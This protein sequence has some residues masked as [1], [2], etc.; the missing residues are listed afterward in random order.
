MNPLGRE[1]GASGGGGPKQER[2][3]DCFCCRFF[4]ITYEQQFPYGCRAARFKSRRMPSREMSA[5]SGMDCQFFS[6]KEKNR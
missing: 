3:I 4:F 2:E 1:G 6:E 5:S